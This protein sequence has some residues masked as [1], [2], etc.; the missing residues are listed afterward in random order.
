MTNEIILDANRLGI[1]LVLQK[2]MQG[3]T[4]EQSLEGSGYSVA[5]FRRI[6]SENGEIA[7]ELI[8]GQKQIIEGQYNAITVARQ[9][10]ISNLLEDALDNRLSVANKLALEERLRTM[11]G[12]LGSALGMGSVEGVDEAQSY[13]KGMKLRPGHAR[14]TQTKTVEIEFNTNKQLQ[15]GEVV[16]GKVIDS[17]IGETTTPT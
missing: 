2:I 14:I 6:I 15:E 17:P 13:L 1:L 11:Q 9:R 10:L 5:T 3:Y 12:A 8:D 16:D 7:K 4:I